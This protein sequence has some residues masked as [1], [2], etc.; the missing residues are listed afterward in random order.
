[1][2]CYI[3]VVLFEQGV[4]FCIAFNWFITLFMSYQFK[5]GFSSFIT[6][7][8]SLKLYKIHGDENPVYTTIL[9]I[10]LDLRC[11]S[12]YPPSKLAMLPNGRYFPIDGHVTRTKAKSAT[13]IYIQNISL[14]WHQ[15]FSSK[16]T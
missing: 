13:Y 2:T 6:H 10:I 11:G 4:R 8:L 5:I 12:V 9:N 7:V 16:H 15:P 1:M 14:S 3:H